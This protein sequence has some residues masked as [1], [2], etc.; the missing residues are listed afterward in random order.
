[1][2]QQLAL[3][4]LQ[5]EALETYERAD[6]TSALG[7]YRQ[8][9]QQAEQI[10]RYAHPAPDS[11]Q[12][13]Y[14]RNM[15]DLTIAGLDGVASCLSAL[16]EF[17][18]AL[19]L[20]QQ[21]LHWLA[22]RGD[23]IRLATVHNRL[24]F[25]YQQLA[26]FENALRA[27]HTALGEAGKAVRS[28]EGALAQQ[29]GDVA[30][31][32]RLINSLTTVR[33]AMMNA[34]TALYQLGRYEEVLR[35]Y[36]QDDWQR[37]ERLFKRVVADL[38]ADSTGMVVRGLRQADLTSDIRVLHD[39]GAAYNA[40][41]AEMGEAAT[42]RQAVEFL[43]QAVQLARQLP[44]HHNFL[45]L[46]ALSSLGAAWEGLKDYPA[47]LVAHTEA[48]RLAH[49]LPAHE[50]RFTMQPNINLTRVALAQQ[51]T[52]TARRLLTRLASREASQDLESLWH[53]HTLYGRLL[54][55]EGNL[56]GAAARFRR[57]IAVT[58]ALRA[59]VLT[60]E[61]KETFFRKYQAP[62]EDLVWV[63]QQMGQPSEAFAIMEKMRARSFADRLA[64]VR[65]T[66]GVPPGLR[67][68]EAIYA[69]QQVQA[70]VLDRRERARTAAQPSASRALT[71]VRQP[72]QAAERTFQDILRDAPPEYA[73][74][75]GGDPVRPEALAAYLDDETVVIS[76]LLG[77]RIAVVATL[78]RGGRMT[79]TPLAPQEPRQI[80]ETVLLLLEQ[81]RHPG[82]QD[83]RPVSARLHQMLIGPV[84]QEIQGYKRLLLI[85]SGLLHYLP[86][87]VLMAPDNGPL[88]V[89][90]HQVVVLPS[91]TALRFA[92]EKNR[93]ERK[94]AVVFALGNVASPTFGALP[95]TLTEAR[96]IQ[97]AMPETQVVLEQQFTRLQVEQLSANR[98]LVHFATHGFLDSRR[99]LQSGI[100][101][102]D[103]PL[104]IAD[105]FDLHLHANL[106]V[107]S[108]CQTG[109]GQ[110]RRGDE[111][112][113]LT[114]AFI[115]AG[116]PSVLSTL[117][118]VAD[119]ST[120]R[121]M[122]LFYQALQVPGTDKG[123]AL[124]T[125]QLALMRTFP[126]PYY[127]APF[128]LLGD[129]Q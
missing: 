54:M 28:I 58:E 77:E 4:I 114:R 56:E 45:L 46:T 73:S 34:A 99:P 41:A 31:T 37:G 21:E 9:W 76:Y 12:A 118:S 78:G 53:V 52:A 106:V 128:Q 36:A 74:L 51:D 83:W 20:Y 84:A 102:A 125:A 60:P 18:E 64:N 107:L 65:I 103:G 29:H 80:E 48:L 25:V 96:D 27:F 105:V 62:Y 119:A 10:Q 121:F 68:Q 16:G 116:T 93:K 63:L 109:L 30:A 38:P 127:W 47:A 1:M 120:A 59:S 71:V 89:E 85:P 43:Q 122:A 69:A 44:D 94:T 92:R 123:R 22:V 87:G 8:L 82:R 3:H 39:R 23:A 81:L 15:D 79:I 17:E 42:Y 113:G 86:F 124:Q 129:W 95:E 101:T 66:K 50:N 7:L 91:A 115:Y 88:L 72:P 70:Y 19:T 6:Y 112:I 110:L 5:H 98:D 26:Q 49:P 61:L 75:Q 11:W 33:S 13:L 24:G 55:L 117:W 90:T 126:H 104:A 108:A 100:V 32:L 111:V 40:L 2:Q 67:E 57:A 35:L 97:Q 14:N